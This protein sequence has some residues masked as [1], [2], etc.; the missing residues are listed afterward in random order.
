MTSHTT[1]VRVQMSFYVEVATESHP[2]DIDAISMRDIIIDNT[3]NIL[4]DIAS[5]HGSMAL[6]IDDYTF[7]DVEMHTEE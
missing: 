4:H 1:K 2:E 6:A 7:E 3:S 5:D